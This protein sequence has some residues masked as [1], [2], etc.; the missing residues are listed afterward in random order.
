MDKKLFI[1][2]GAVVLG[3][4][5]LS[6]GFYAGRVQAD[7]LSVTGSAKRLV[8][9]DTAEMTLS[10]SRS[11]GLEGLRDGY[12]QMKA[13]EN[14]ITAFLSARGFPSEVVSVTAVSLEE[15]NRWTPGVVQEYILRQSVTVT[16]P[17]IVLVSDLAKSLQPLVDGGMILA[18][19]Q[20]EYYYNKLA[21][22]RIEL[23]GEAVKDARSRAETIATNGGQKLGSLMSATMGV[24]QVLSPN[25]T[26]VSDYGSYDTTTQE[27][28]V[29]VTVRASFR[30][31]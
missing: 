6:V 18:P 3:A 8:T 7:T 19:Q 12:A 4:I 2:P 17:D 24:V 1:M 25:S 29:M 9:A 28:E 20:P 10:W 31:R 22:L 21:D 23:L 11:V 15:P 16:S 13:D 27:K 30:V 5:V 26:D 14:T